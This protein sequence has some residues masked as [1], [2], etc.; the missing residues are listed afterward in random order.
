[1]ALEQL[2]DEALTAYCDEHLSDDALAAALEPSSRCA[3]CQPPNW[4]QIAKG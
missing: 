3:D 2:G 1:M 4:Q